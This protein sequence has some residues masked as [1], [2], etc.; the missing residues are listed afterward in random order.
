MCGRCWAR[1]APLAAPRCA[2]CGHPTAHRECRWCPLLP[3]FVRA[4]RSACSEQ[5][6]TARAIVHALKY[7]GWTQVAQG[8]AERMATLDWPRDVVEERAF[9][10][11]VPLAPSRLRERGFNQS[12][13]LAEAL[14]THW[15]ITART[16]CLERARE[17]T[18]QTRLTPGERLANVSGAFRATASARPALR[19]AHVLLVDDVVT[20]AATL[21]ACAAALHAGGARILSYVT[22]GRAPAAGD[23]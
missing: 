4:V 21:N 16:D 7:A 8:M 18:S 2:R 12:A 14:A 10:V 15:R 6:G 19:G 13:L 20:T 17:T 22:F 11:P 9:I 5:G 1:L 3:P 23:R